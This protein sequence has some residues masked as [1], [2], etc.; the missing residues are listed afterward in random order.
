VGENISNLQERNVTT[1]EKLS[2]NKAEQKQAVSEDDV[3]MT[4]PHVRRRS[5]SS[6]P[7]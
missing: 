6:R 1:N 3:Q 4:D 2:N 5:V 7:K